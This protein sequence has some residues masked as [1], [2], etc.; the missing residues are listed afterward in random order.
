MICD[1]IDDCIEVFEKPLENC[2]DPKGGKS[3]FRLVNTERKNFSKINF[4]DCVYEGKENETKCDYAFIYDNVIFYVELKGSDVRKGYAQLSATI[5]ETS[6]C[7]PEK[8]IKARMVV[9][10]NNAPNIA[11]KSVGYKKLIRKTTDIIV[12]QKVLIE[13]IS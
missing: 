11:R 12:K 5:A 6:K 7:F 10:K 8:A 2:T 3:T 13:K 4:E 1:K 9:S